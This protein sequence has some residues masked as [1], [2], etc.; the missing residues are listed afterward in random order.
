MTTIAVPGLAK[1]ISAVVAVGATALLVAAASAPD[2]RAVITAPIPADVGPTPP[3][4][5]TFPVAGEAAP[6]ADAIA[7]A[8][9]PS[10][11]CGG[12]SR[13]DLYADAWP[14]A[15]SWWEYRCTYVYPPP[16]I[17]ACNADWSPSIWI[18]YFYWDGSKPVFYGESYGDYYYG[19]GCDYWW[20]QPSGGWY[21]LDTAACP[22]SGPGNAAPSAAFTYSCSGLTCNFDG[23]S[24]WASD[25]IVASRWDFGDGTSASG[26]IASHSYD[27]K[28]TYRVTL[29]VTDS[30]GL[31]AASRNTVATTDIPPTARF[32]FTCSGL[33]CSFDGSPSAD[34]DGTIRQY[35]WSFG[36]GYSAYGSSSAQNTYAQP[37]SYRVRLDVT[38]DAGLDTVF[39]QTVTVVGTSTDLPPTAS[40]SFSCTGLT[41]HFDGSGSSD[42][43]G[44]IVAYQWSF[45]DYV[46]ASMVAPGFD[47][48][49]LQSGT[50][51][52][53]LK[54]IDNGKQTATAGKT[55]TV[56]VNA[57]PAPAFTYTCTGLTCSFDGSASTDTDGTIATYSWSFGDGTSGSGQI[58]AQTYTR[59]TPYVVTLT[60]TDNAG[61]SVAAVRTVTPIALSARGYKVKGNAKV[62]LSWSGP[63]SAGF[64]VYRN[65]ARIAALQSTSYTDNVNSKAPGSYTYRVCAELSS[66]SNDATVNF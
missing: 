50:Y 6:P 32:M 59:A 42:S 16:C 57:P 37:G 34:P 11:T 40:F 14:A 35:Y 18:D 22:F 13:Q 54:V 24:S 1:R 58:V 52:V 49:Y 31:G 23:S 10:A 51:T 48:T 3:P 62:D 30:G 5:A 56:G 66:C 61:V 43:D 46:G 29:T 44:T 53:T 20:D 27:T 38:D 15:S 55:V 65:G 36:D 21:A 63:S 12:W 4:V 47:H 60:V 7:D 2:A 33:T 41:C 26:V 39:E 17:G 45:G 8:V 64:D 19:S 25:G 28:R 9:E